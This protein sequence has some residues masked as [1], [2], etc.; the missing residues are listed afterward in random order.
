M[1]LLF[2]DQRTSSQ[3]KKK[4]KNTNN[5]LEADTLV[6]DGL[7]REFRSPQIVAIYHETQ[8]FGMVIRSFHCFKIGSYKFL[9]EGCSVY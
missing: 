4:K 9:A 1:S 3:K 8:V 7:D 2:G 6:S 5:S